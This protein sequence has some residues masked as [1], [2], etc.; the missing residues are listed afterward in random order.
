VFYGKSIHNA[1]GDKHQSMQALV[2]TRRRE[3]LMEKLNNSNLKIQV[4]KKVANQKIRLV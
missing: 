4:L 1:E 3:E 2:V